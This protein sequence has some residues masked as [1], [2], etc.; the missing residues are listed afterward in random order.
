MVS[1]V[2]I[3]LFLYLKCLY[4]FWAIVVRHI[5]SLRRKIIQVYI[6]LNNKIWGEVALGM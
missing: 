1:I 3:F 6:F 4:S 2:I 5:V